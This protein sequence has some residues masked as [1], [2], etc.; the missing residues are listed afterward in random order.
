MGLRYR[1]QNYQVGEFNIRLRMLR[2]LDE[3]EDT[4][5]R[6]EEAG[7]SK[8][9]F[10]LFG[11]VWASS[12]V[13]SRL[14]LGYDLTN[15]RVLEIG[16]GMALASHVMNAGGVDITAMD[17]HPVT[18]E[19]ITSNAILNDAPKIPFLNASWGDDT[20]V[21]GE[22]DLIV[23][24]D[25]LYEPKHIKTLATFLDRHARSSSEVLIVDPDRGQLEGFQADM[26][27]AGFTCETFSPD[28]EDHLGIRYNGSIL[29]YAR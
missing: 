10:P 12:E 25:V 5:G 11:I 1:Y 22:F 17:I 16:C 6:A 3:L 19:L 20:S 4:G 2:D 29:R 28:F 24:S 14:M 7:I 13:L 21:L 9:A 26:A 18:E 23:G 27:A 8:E 15:K